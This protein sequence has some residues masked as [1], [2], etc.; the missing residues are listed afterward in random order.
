MART[1]FQV[2]ILTPEGTVFDDQVEMISTMTSVGS[3]GVMAN[4]TPLLAMLNSCELRLHRDGGE[5]LR[6]AQ[7]EGYMQVADNRAMILV[8]EAVLATD[9]NP[10]AIEADLAEWRTKLEAAEVDSEAARLA[11]RNVARLEAFLQVAGNS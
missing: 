7:A 4:H 9:L 5:I 8:E 11:E 1:P 2:E 3:V 6:F 10:A